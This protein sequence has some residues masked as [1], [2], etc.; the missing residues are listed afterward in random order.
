[1]PNDTKV[2]F[3]A[4][5]EDAVYDNAAEQW[6]WDGLQH[7]P[8]AWRQRL[9]LRSD[10]Y[11]TPALV[12]DETTPLTGGSSGRVDALDWYGTWKWLDALTSCAFE[13]VYCGYAFGNTPEQRG[14]GTW[15]DGWPA[16]EAVV[17][18]GPKRPSTRLIYLPNVD[19]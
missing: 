2:L 11:G 17:T 16:R 10:R 18:D 19:G 7:V 8:G 1:V 6:L 15:A 5:E 13:G 14:M 4:M 9:L 3:V 12:A